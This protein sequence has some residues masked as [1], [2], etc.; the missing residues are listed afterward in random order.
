MPRDLRKSQEI[1]SV[2]SYVE[3]EKSADVSQHVTLATTTLVLTVVCIAMLSETD[4]WPRRVIAGMIHSQSS[5]SRNQT[6]PP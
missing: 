4:G 2:Q 1:R 3:G 5:Y 6:P